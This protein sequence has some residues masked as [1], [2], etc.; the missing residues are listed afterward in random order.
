MIWSAKV[1]TPTDLMFVP[2]CCD[3]NTGVARCGQWSPGR[4]TMLCA[5]TSAWVTALPQC[6]SARNWYP[7]SGCG[8]RATSPATK[9][10][11][12]VTALTS[13]ARQP[14]SQATPPDTHGQARVAQPFGVADRA[15]GRHGHAG[16]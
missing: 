9:M 15:Q 6:S 5:A 14:A 16:I 1:G 3:Q 2:N 11:S 8:K 13:N 12:V 10:S 4:L 7:Y